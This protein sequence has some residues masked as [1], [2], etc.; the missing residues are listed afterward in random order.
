MAAL[1]TL[2]CRRPTIN[3]L[4]S[5]TVRAVLS[6]VERTESAVTTRGDSPL[7]APEAAT[8][9]EQLKK[10][11][12]E[13]RERECMGEKKLSG[14]HDNK[15]RRRDT[16]FARFGFAARGMKTPLGKRLDTSGDLELRRRKVKTLSFFPQ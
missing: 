2:F 1:S 3:A 15:R 12:K 4:F 9:V 16:P 13:G 10:N 11:N 5:L 7:R 6:A 8:A 14:V